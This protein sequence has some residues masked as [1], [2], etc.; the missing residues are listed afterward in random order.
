MKIIIVTGMSGAGK[1]TALNVLEDC[2]YYCVDNMPIEL[3][4]RFAKLAEGQKGYSNIALGVDIRNVAS[5]NEMEPV[6]DE[7]K[8]GNYECKILFLDASD[9]V[10]V[11]RYKETR[12]SIPCRPVLAQQL[13]LVRLIARSLLTGHMPLFHQIILLRTRLEDPLHIHLVHGII[14]NFGITFQLTV[15]IPTCV[16]VC[17]IDTAARAR[18]T[19]WQHQQQGEHD[20]KNSR[21]SHPSTPLLLKIFK[22]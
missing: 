12:R 7:M 15:I 19:I 16:R 21:S 10:L 13:V 14:N 20:S 9:E 2:E 22:K 8:S 3:I 18:H 4:P 1:S 11:K 6:L 17:C 5:I